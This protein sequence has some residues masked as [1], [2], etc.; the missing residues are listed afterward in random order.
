MEIHEPL[1]D[2]LHVHFDR[3]YDLAATFLRFQEHYESPKF[4]GKIFTL[5]EYRRWYI[6][7]SAKGR[8]TRKFT[9]YKDWEGFNVPSDV[10]DPFYQGDFDPLS[11]RE[12]IFLQLFRKR[13]GK[14]FYVIGTSGDENILTLKHEI[15]HGL[16]YTRPAYRKTVLS[17]LREIPD[18]VRRKIQQ[19]FASSRD[20]HPRVFYDETH[21]YV[22]TDLHTLQQE[23]KLGTRMLIDISEKLEANFQRVSHRKF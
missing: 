5:K 15:A 23:T 19:F 20:Y 14:L 4:R 3:Q 17:I 22:L 21:A 7:H 2:I 11:E 6:A 10:L 16:F 13:R 1:K 18:N 12:Q 8:K 9:Y